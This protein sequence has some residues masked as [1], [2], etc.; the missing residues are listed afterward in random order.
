MDDS[1]NLEI[2]YTLANLMDQVKF[3]TNQLQ[4]IQLH[5]ADFEAKDVQVYPTLCRYCNVPHMSIDC[6]MEDPFAQVQPP[7]LP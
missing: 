2:Q 6:Q 4:S 5:N 1:T 3:L 7:R